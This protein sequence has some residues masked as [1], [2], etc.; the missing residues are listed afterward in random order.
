MDVNTALSLFNGQPKIL[1]A[2]QIYQLTKAHFENILFQGYNLEQIK[3]GL[4]LLKQSRQIQVPTEARALDL[5]ITR[6][7]E[8]IDRE[9]NPYGGKTRQIRNKKGYSKKKSY[10]KRRASRRR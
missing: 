7:G 2:G 9:K 1:N 3:Q 4:V 10:K 8:I 6:I 5:L